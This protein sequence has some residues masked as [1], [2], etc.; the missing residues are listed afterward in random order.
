MK[1]KGFLA[2][3]F[4]TIVLALF[5][6]SCNN[7]ANPLE[8]QYRRDSIENARKIDS[9]TQVNL[10]MV[11]ENEDISS[12]LAEIQTG[13]NEISEAES[14]VRESGLEK[15]TAPEAIRENMRRIGEL[16]EKNESMIEQLKAKLKESSSD[17]T[18]LEAA[19]NQL[20]LQMEKKNAE[21]EELRLQLA[22]RDKQI[23]SLGESVEQLSSEN[24]QV[25]QEKAETEEVVRHQDTQLNTAWYVF[26][27]KKE[28]KAHNIL[29]G[30]EVLM[31][32][33]DKSYFTQIDIRQVK[34]IPFGSKH[35]DVLTTHPAASYTLLKENDGT[36]TLKIED[37]SL[38]WSV[39]KYLVVKVR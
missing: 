31:G 39:S 7:G 35:V 33:Y 14:V 22:E 37:P 38:F 10:R 6:S 26:G 1:T 8:D 27:T 20:Q 28:L 23:A 4:A 2:Q 5:V 9:L 25:R 32:E 3:V 34:I 11:S 30:R 18:K 15:G 29:N 13:L 24:Q 17:N 36:R 21:I 16:M 12:L 19:L